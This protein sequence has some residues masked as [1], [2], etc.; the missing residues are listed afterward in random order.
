MSLGH[1]SFMMAKLLRAIFIF[2][3]LAPFQIDLQTGPIYKTITTS[4]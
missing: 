2:H 4:D 1:A 3:N